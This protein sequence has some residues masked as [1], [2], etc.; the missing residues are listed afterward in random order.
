MSAIGKAIRDWRVANGVS[1]SEAA[2]EAGVGVVE[3]GEV[4]RGLVPAAEALRA[5]FERARE[6]KP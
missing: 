1:L 2:Q 3:L 6:A 4:E 5:W